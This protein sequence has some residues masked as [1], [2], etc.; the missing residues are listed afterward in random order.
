MA[1]NANTDG[2]K[3]KCVRRSSGMSGV[4]LTPS[5]DGRMLDGRHSLN[6][7]QGS[8]LC[9]DSGGNDDNDHDENGDDDGDDGGGDNSSQ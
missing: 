4:A 3:Y 1:T 2:G 8:I 6:I 5:A 7:L 9:F